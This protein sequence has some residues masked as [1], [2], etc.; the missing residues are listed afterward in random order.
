M[1]QLQTLF[2]HFFRYL[3]LAGGGGEGG[4]EARCIIKINPWR[5]KKTSKNEQT[6]LKTSAMSDHG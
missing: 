5:T 1:I 4:R 3:G 2:I 6:L